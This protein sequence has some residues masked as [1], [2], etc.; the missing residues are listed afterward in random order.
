MSCV[1][2][3]SMP[4]RS[5]AEATTIFLNSTL[6][7]S[8]TGTLTSIGSMRGIRRALDPKVS[9]EYRDRAENGGD[10]DHC[11]S[12]APHPE[13]PC[14]CSLLLASRYGRLLKKQELGSVGSIYFSIVV[15]ECSAVLVI[16]L[17]LD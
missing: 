15:I 6:G 5:G 12:L 13:N 3:S 10:A 8:G 16:D 1:R 17:A 14:M 9:G 4:K 7:S 11:D 2:S